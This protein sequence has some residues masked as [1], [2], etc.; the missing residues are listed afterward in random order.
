MC[1][2]CG[3]KG[4]E[5]FEAREKK[6]GGISIAKNP[7]FPRGT[8]LQAF[9]K[10]NRSELRKLFGNPNYGG[11]R[12]QNNEYNLI[13]GGKRVTIYDVREESKRGTK[14][15]NIG[16]QSLMGAVILAQIISAHRGERVFAKETSPRWIEDERRYEEVSS[17]D[18]HPDLTYEQ[19]E[20][21]DRYSRQYRTRRFGAED[22]HPKLSA[23]AKSA[24]VFP[25]T[26]TYPIGDLKHGKIALVY[27]TWPDNKKDAQK[28]RT[29]V[30]KKYPSLRKWFKDGKYEV[31]GA[32]SFEAKGCPHCELKNCGYDEVA[33]YCPEAARIINEQEGMMNV[34]S[35]FDAEGKALRRA[36]ALW[37]NLVYGSRMGFLELHMGEMNLPLMVRMGKMKMPESIEELSKAIAES[38]KSTARLL[39]NYAEHNGWITVDM[40]NG[41]VEGAGFKAESFGAEQIDLDDF[42]GHTPGEWNVSKAQ[43]NTVLVEANALGCSDCGSTDIYTHENTGGKEIQF[44]NSVEPRPFTIPEGKDWRMGYR[45]YCPD[46][47]LYDYAKAVDATQIEANIRLIEAA[48]MLLAELKRM[49][50]GQNAE[51]FGVEGKVRTMSGKPHTP[52]KLV[53]DKN[54]TPKEAAKRMKLEAEE[55]G[56]ES[57]ES[58]TLPCYCERCDNYTDL[59]GKGWILLSGELLCPNCES[60]ESSTL[61]VVCEQ[62]DNYEDLEGEGW[63]LLSGE[64]LCPNCGLKEYK[65]EAN[66]EGTF[67]NDGRIAAGIVFMP[68]MKD[69]ESFGLMDAEYAFT[70]GL[71]PDELVSEIDNNSKRYTQ[72][73]WGWGQEWDK[74]NMDTILNPETFNG[75]M[76]GEKPFQEYMPDISDFKSSM[77]LVGGLLV[78]LLGY[79]KVIDSKKAETFNASEACSEDTDCPEGKV[80]VDGKCLPICVDDGDCASWQE[81]RDDLHPTEKVCG[82]DKND[83]NGNPFT[84]PFNRG[85][86]D[87]ENPN[88]APTENSTTYSTTT[89]ALFGVGIVGAIGIGIKVLGGMQ[90]KESGE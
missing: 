82:E 11:M 80:C 60:K 51:E 15:F 30:F 4:A 75:E 24:Y 34:R 54:I 25:K 13:L 86:K 19:A 52:R 69:R 7:N 36:D 47:D 58:S 57:R 62:C 6:I 37:Y 85:D 65:S 78:G 23:K 40:R 21:S 1:E 29:A 41:I 31:K 32:E 55:F 18:G 89:K 46:C 35:R 42:Y 27:S 9:M 83:S 76:M 49:R 48:P 43:R 68:E 56:A 72:F 74:L 38:P 53:K 22:K 64:L 44:P 8:S 66:G 77:I 84:D 79:N 14:Y 33:N 70:F 17:I 67:Y 3:C 20:E 71:S 45:M 16:S 81:C 50:E 5:T 2:T 26:Q 63:S 88:D 87:V 90:D 39:A 28:V 59:D 10:T 12:G 73:S 61:P